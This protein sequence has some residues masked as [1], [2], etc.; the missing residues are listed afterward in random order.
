MSLLHCTDMSNNSKKAIVKTISFIH[1]ISTRGILTF[2]HTVSQVR[3]E[4]D[5]LGET[6]G[7]QVAVSQFDEKKREKKLAQS[8]SSPVY[9]SA[10]TARLK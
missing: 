3:F 1:L 2:F 4:I 10:A 6:G 8:R 9:G 5:L 7:K